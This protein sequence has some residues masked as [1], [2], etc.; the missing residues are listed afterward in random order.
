MSIK[1]VICCV[2][3]NVFILFEKLKLLSFEIIMTSP[4]LIQSNLNGVLKLPVSN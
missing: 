4:I 3:K 2:I 1:S